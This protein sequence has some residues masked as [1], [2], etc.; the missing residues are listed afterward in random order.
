M[1][2]S[3]DASGAVAQPANLAATAQ[4]AD[5]GD[6]LSNS[7]AIIDFLKLHQDAADGR[8]D[9]EVPQ[10]SVVPADVAADQPGCGG[11]ADLRHPGWQLVFQPVGWEPGARYSPRRCGCRSSPGWVSWAW[12]ASLSCHRT[13]RPTRAATRRRSG[14]CRARITRRTRPSAS[15][16]HPCGAPAAPAC[17]GIGAP[18]GAAA[19]AAPVAPAAMIAYAVKM[20]PEEGRPR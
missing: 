16:P 8:R 3:M 18:A 12:S 5:S 20:D 4:A 1:L 13:P 14:T 9:L 7:N 10:G 11:A 6:A 17:R 19:P 15:R 2:M